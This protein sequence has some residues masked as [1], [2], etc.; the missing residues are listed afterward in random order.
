MPEKTSHLK[1]HC[2]D[3]NDTCT[4]VSRVWQ[5]SARSCAY[6]SKYKSVHVC[7][8]AG[9]VCTLFSFD[10]MC[11]AS[12]QWAIFVNFSHNV[13][14]AIISAKALSSFPQNWVSHVICMNKFQS[15]HLPSLVVSQTTKW[16]CGIEML[17]P[18]SSLS[19][20]ILI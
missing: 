9:K 5:F 3:Q 10:P 2:E 4:P 6:K 20:L 8:S 12:F 19:Q 18:K 13:C 16:G 7:K 11:A 17:C 14:L 1:N 15:F